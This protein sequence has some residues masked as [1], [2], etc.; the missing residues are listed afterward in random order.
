MNSGARLLPAVYI[1]HARQAPAVRRAESSGVEICALHRIVDE[2]SEKSAQVE[3][4][5][6]R[7]TIEQHEVLV[8]LATADVVS[9]IVIVAGQ[10]SRKQLHYAEHVGLAHPRQL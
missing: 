7:N 5:V 10:D 1:Q 2:G 9:R 8:R 4:V 3:R 6:Y